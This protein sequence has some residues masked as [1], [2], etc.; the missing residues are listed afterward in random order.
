MATLDSGLA[1][2]LQRARRAELRVDGSDLARTFEYTRG[3][4][5]TAVRLAEQVVEGLPEAARAELLPQVRQWTSYESPAAVRAA[6]IDASK[7]ARLA[8]VARQEVLRR[9]MELWGTRRRERPPGPGVAVIAK[10][11]VVLCKGGD[12]Y[13]EVLLEDVLEEGESG[14]LLEDEPSWL[15]P[16]EGDAP[17][18]VWIEESDPANGGEMERQCDCCG[19]MG[20]DCCGGG[21]LQKTRAHKYL[22]RIPTGKPRPKYRY[23]YR[24]P[25]GRHVV[26]DELHAGTKLKVAH[27]GQEGHLEVLH[28]DKERGIVHARHDE[29]GK[30]VHIKHADLKRMVA[31]YHAKRTADRQVKEA[32]ASGKPAPKALP[33]ATMA[34]LTKGEYEQIEGF[35]MRPEELEA[36]A[37]ASPGGREYAVVK[38]PT[39]YVLVS[40]APVKAGDAKGP[41][42]GARTEVKLRSAT[43]KGIES[44]KA[45]YV[46]LE[47]DDIIA[48]HKPNAI[49]DFPQ[50]PDYPEHVQE[51]RY[52]K[53]SAEQEKVQRI[54]SGLDPAIMVNSNPDAVNGPPIVTQD[55]VVLGGNGR[56]MAVQMAYAAYPDSGEALKTYLA[57]QAHAFGF[58][59]ADV[60]RMKRP[61][62][63]RK[64][65]ADPGTDNANLRLLGRRMNEALTQ[66]LDPRSEDVALSQFVTA[67]VTDAMVATMDPDERLGDFLYSAR[68]EEFVN[69]LRRAGVI[70]DFNKAQ[71]IENNGEGK[72]L[73]DDGRRRVERILAA[74]MVPDADVLERMN[75][76][77]R[78]SLAMSTASFL[79]AENNGWDLREPLRL[80]VEADLEA[81]EMYKKNTAK[82]QVDLYLK[83]VN[84]DP[85]TPQGRIGK[86]P[87]AKML[88]RVVRFHSGTNKMPTGF[89]G[90]AARAAIDHDEYGF[91]DS[92]RGSVGMFGGMESARMTPAEAMD[93]EFGISPARAKAKKAREDAAKKEAEEAKKQAAEA[94]K[95][96]DSQGSMF[97]SVSGRELPTL[98]K[99]SGRNAA[100]DRVTAL[101]RMAVDAHAGHSARESRGKKIQVP[102]QRIVRQVLADVAD[103]ALRDPAIAAGITQVD[104]PTVRG[105][106]QAA[107]AMRGAEI[108]KGFRLRLVKAATGMRPPGTGWSPV[109]NSKHGGWY[110]LVGGRRIYWYPGESGG[111]FGGD[112]VGLPGEVEE[113]PPVTAA[114]A[115]EEAESLSH[116]REIHRADQIVGRVLRDLGDD[117]VPRT[118]KT[119]AAW[120]AVKA[121]LEAKIRRSRSM[122]EITTLQERAR[123]TAHDAAEAARK[124]ELAQLTLFD[125][126]H[127]EPESPELGRGQIQDLA[128]EAFRA[129][130]EGGEDAFIAHMKTLRAKYGPMQARAIIEEVGVRK[131][132]GG[133]VSSKPF[134]KPKPAGAPATRGGT[135]GG[136]QLGLFG[137]RGL[138]SGQTGSLFDQGVLARS[139]GG[140]LM[141]LGIDP[142]REVEAARRAWLEL[143]ELLGKAMWEASLQK[144]QAHKYLRRVPTGKPRPKYRY[145]YKVTGGKGLGHHD[146]FQVGGKF[147]VEGGHYEVIAVDGDAVTIRHDETGEEARMPKRDLSTLLRAHHAPK[148]EAKR[149]SLKRELAAVAVHGS[150]KQKERLQAEA[151][152]FHGHFGG[153]LPDKPKGL[154]VDRARELVAH[155]P[156]ARRALVTEDVVK[157]F[158]E[159]MGAAGIPMKEGAF[160]AWFIGEPGVADVGKPQRIKVRTWKG[161]GWEATKEVTADALGNDW[162]KPGM[163]VVA[164]PIPPEHQDPQIQVDQIKT[165]NVGDDVGE[166]GMAGV[167]V[168][169]R[170]Y[171]GKGIA[172]TLEYLVR[173]KPK[174]KTGVAKP[175][176][177]DRAVALAQKHGIPIEPAG[178]RSVAI[179]GPAAYDKDLGKWNG[180]RGPGGR[181][182]VNTADAVA[183]LE[184]HGQEA[185]EQHR[186]NVEVGDTAE[187]RRRQGLVLSAP[188][189]FDFKDEIKAAGGIWDREA[190]AWLMPSREVMAPLEAKMRAARYQ[191]SDERERQF[192]ESRRAA[193]QQRQDQPDQPASLKQVDYA[194]KLVRKLFESDYGTFTTLGLQG[195]TQGELTKMGSR[196]ISS[197]IDAIRDELEG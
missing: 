120:P 130:K 23:I 126:V 116:M 37:A 112:Q 132:A 118:L 176:A 185:G 2:L 166:G 121:A 21:G 43:G 51:R 108:V 147:K 46:L 20:C 26:D 127:P 35:A 8:P 119:A 40:R 177:V 69:A 88:L 195:T 188:N 73:N 101:V 165:L 171:Y 138:G 78:E 30:T 50:R 94:K 18:L 158:G 48:S 105:L 98:L 87:T 159:T 167:V 162:P 56:T 148:I 197:L 76:T 34:D 141:M 24:L 4:G 86:D 100:M 12:S 189:T 92:A 168:G 55:G 124:Y 135:A 155:W 71:L 190:K 39:G 169:K 17:E 113:V 109:P 28:H 15:A 95:Q 145:F 81:R 151:E 67:D 183:W 192:A 164:A 74:R 79:I 38:Q 75:P 175:S 153:V 128:K 33:R 85:E 131:T 97:A 66:G 178:A 191:A 196:R 115:A 58:K 10:A 106:V 89:R 3:S 25:S 52:H 137:M 180:V 16:Q 82:E 193:E 99:A 150:P 140:P 13:L 110:K 104:E 36:Q 1:P 170:V 64:V 182:I 129:G 154:T 70:D 6:V 32:K 91:S 72:L 184:K 152:Q 186:R 42:T 146:E 68:S 161:K 173:P 47:A 149:A 7:A 22:K 139:F 123:E 102:V 96:A 84:T 80:A 49:G 111:R 60:R 44:L 5:E 134:A 114:H 156:E 142:A 83:Q 29:S 143:P 125:D 157:R 160:A 117:K 41:K 62:I 57:S 187:A 90:V 11:Q 31:G 179:G 77:L 53:I 65:H 107:V 136:E 93:I 172:R 19:G 181:R 103:I 174:P 9:S 59:A 163:W 14:E 63:V 27:A 122:E 45:E 144:G 194:W 54:A 61:M 133:L